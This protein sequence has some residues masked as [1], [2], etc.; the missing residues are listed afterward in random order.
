MGS[1]NTRKKP[2][3]LHVVPVPLTLAAFF[4]GQ[5]EYMKKKGF[6]VAVISSP[7][8]QLDFVERRDNINIYQVPMLR[9]ISPLADIIALFRIFKI[10]RKL[11]PTIVHAH[12][13][14]AGLLGMIA[15]YLARVPVRIFTLHG[16]RSE[17]LEGVKKMIVDINVKLTCRLAQ[18][19]F[20]V[21]NSTCQEALNLGYCSKD[22]IKVLANGSYNGVDARSRFN[23]ERYAKEVRRQIRRKYGIPQNALVLGCVSR[24][25]RDKGIVE[26]VQAWQKLRVE[27]E[28]LYLLLMVSLF[29][30]ENPVNP[31][32]VQILNNDDR[33]VI[34]GYVYDMPEHYLAADLVPLPTYREGFPYSLL[35]GAAM[36]LPVV[37]TRV[38]GCVDAVEDGRTGILVPAKDADA[39]YEAIRKLL[40]DKSLREKLGRAG[41]QHALKHF[42]PEIVWAALHSE[43]VG[44]MQEHNVC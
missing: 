27:F 1:T 7:G 14:K 11:Q 31:E 4:A 37:A 10:M 38:T 2:L 8:P 5:I 41:R 25:V 35:E 6:E 34:T 43:Y 36:E 42:A 18:R 32:V 9:R 39:L 19:V 15:A 13:T 23:P 26:L 30:S 16:I 21:S 24:I 29:E 17:G 28:N 3:L 22:K 33:I 20:A 40:L 12:I 44:L